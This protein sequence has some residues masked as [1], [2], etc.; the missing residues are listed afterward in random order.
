M[1]KRRAVDYFG[2]LEECDIETENEIDAINIRGNRD[3][4]EASDVIISQVSDETPLYKKLK[5]GQNIAVRLPGSE[6]FHVGVIKSVIHNGYIS[7]KY[8]VE[9]PQ[10]SSMET[11]SWKDISVDHVSLNQSNLCGKME[12]Q[13]SKYENVSLAINDPSRNPILSRIQMNSLQYFSLVQQ[14]DSE[15]FVNKAFK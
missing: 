7:A 4:I 15:L 6:S 10:F 14:L 9:F 11:V 13:E 8:D 3:N 2:D 5:T 1:M 12:S